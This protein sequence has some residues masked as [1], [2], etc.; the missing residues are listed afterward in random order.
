[1]RILLLL[2]LSLGVFTATKAQT[3]ILEIDS[4]G[5]LE[6][7]SGAAYE[8][9]TAGGIK[10][11][12]FEGIEGDTFLFKSKSMHYKE[13]TAFRNV[14]RKTFLDVLAYPA[15]VG[16]CIAMSAF[17]LAYAKGYFLSDTDIMISS[18]GAFLLESVIFATSR[19]YLKRN[20]KWINLSS[21][22]ELNYKKWP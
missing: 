8:V 1:M 4:I 11:M 13:I 21:L 12:F 14:K 5:T 22:P 19:S 7:K 6:L 16:S 17:P 20:K 18:L 3:Y 15:T 9:G 10:L 2:L